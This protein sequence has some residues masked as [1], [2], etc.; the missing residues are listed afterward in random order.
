[1]TLQTLGRCAAAMIQSRESLL[2]GRR[3]TARVV[4]TAIRE[5]GSVKRTAVKLSNQRK[6]I[7]NEVDLLQCVLVN[8]VFKQLPSKK[9]TEIKGSIE[10]LLNS[11]A[12]CFV[13]VNT[14]YRHPFL[15]VLTSPG[16]V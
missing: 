7:N 3:R 4:P 2:N 5:T 14:Q 16:T 6:M 15:E 10:V 9:K 12:V 13:I 1:M 8:E 11:L